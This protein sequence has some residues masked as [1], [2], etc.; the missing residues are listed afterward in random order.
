MKADI[1]QSRSYPEPRHFTVEGENPMTKWMGINFCTGTVIANDITGTKKTDGFKKGMVQLQPINKYGSEVIEF[2]DKEKSAGLHIG[3]PVNIYYTTDENDI[4]VILDVELAQNVEK[5]RIAAKDLGFEST[6]D[7]ICWYDENNNKKHMNVDDD[8]VC[9]YNGKLY[10]RPY[11]LDDLFFEYGTVTLTDTDSDGKAEVISI[12]KTDI[13]VVESVS[14]SGVIADKYDNPNLKIDLSDTDTDIKVIRDDEEVSFDAIKKN[15]ILSVAKSKDNKCITLIISIDKI[16]GALTE[17][18]EDT[19]C[20]DGVEYTLYKPNKSYFYKLDFGEKN[21]FYLTDDKV[22]VGYKS[23]TDTSGRIYGYATVASIKD[24]GLNKGKDARIRIFNSESSKIEAYDFVDNPSLNGSYYATSGEK[25]TPA[26]LV[27]ALEVYPSG[28]E[29]LLFVNQLVQFCLNEEGV[30]N[31]LY[32]AV[33]NTKENGGTGDYCDEFSKDFSF[34]NLTAQYPRVPYKSFGVMDTHYNLNGTNGIRVPSDD[35]WAQFYLGYTSL[36]Y[37]ESQI[38]GFVPYRKWINDYALLNVDAYD[39]QEDN[40]CGFIVEG[41][42]SAA[43]EYPEE[44][45]F[46]V[47]KMVYGLDSEECPA[48]LLYGCYKGEYGS[49]TVS[50][51]IPSD[52]VLYPGDVIRIRFNN[53]NQVCQIYKIFTLYEKN[54]DEYLLNGNEFDCYYNMGD[55]IYSNYSHENSSNWN[56]P[57]IVMH[58]RYS[59][60]KDLILSVDL[61]YRQDG[62]SLPIQKRLGV[63]NKSNFYV[64]DEATETMKIG[65]ANDIQFND[66]KQTAVIQS[67]YF[68]HHSVILINHKDYQDNIYWNGSFD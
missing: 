45:F 63:I 53:L 54:K 2:L 44:E 52:F 9:F 16:K 50:N 29:T 61:G 7:K 23:V 5:Y 36:D 43:S 68:E 27:K 35:I 34:R 60:K 49:W 28:K 47:E 56:S 18:S 66:P 10:A 37:M 65:S 33:D 26:S 39:V 1:L 11:N 46:A 17:I 15:Q 19:I 4:N 14:E 64:Y 30:I 13:Y 38:Q 32:S 12:Y 58:A 59:G 20:I 6:W 51:D 48:R 42:K 62:E 8:A 21:T 24:S 31:A 55:F 67:R 25:Y 3:C 57:H 22:V 40:T 41:L